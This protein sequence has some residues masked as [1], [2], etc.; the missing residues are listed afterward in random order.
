[1]KG[2]RLRLDQKLTVGDD[3][4]KEFIRDDSYTAL[5]WIKQSCPDTIMRMMKE[6]YIKLIILLVDECDVPLVKAEETKTRIITDKVVVVERF[7]RTLDTK[8]QRSSLMKK[9]VFAMMMSAVMCVTGLSACGGNAADATQAPATSAVE[10]TAAAEKTTDKADMTPASEKETADDALAK[11]EAIGDV[12]VEKGLFDVTLTIPKD[13]AG[14]VTQEELDEL[15]KEKGFQSAT[16][17]SD[18]SVTYVMTK[19]QHKEMVD[20][21]AEKIKNALSEM[22]ESADYPN[23]TDIS[24]NDDFTVFTVTTKNSTPDMA[25]SFVVLGLYMYGGMYAIFNGETAENIHVDYVNA[26]SGEV[27]SSADSKGMGKN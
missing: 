13:F 12:D 20:G 14:E 8:V 4:F 27:I 24:A 25:E 26:D 17:N 10:V 5:M 18:G 11:L 2:R 6:V 3:I 22:A 7:E 19:A 1:M 21:V 23:I 16:L 15:V 9:K